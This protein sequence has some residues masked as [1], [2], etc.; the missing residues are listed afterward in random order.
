MCCMSSE[1]IGS[2]NKHREFSQDASTVSEPGSH[3]SLTDHARSATTPR[4]QGQFTT[5]QLMR[6]GDTQLSACGP[7]NRAK[8][9]HRNSCTGSVCALPRV[10][11]L[12]LMTIEEE[13]RIPRQH[14]TRTWK[15]ARR[16]RTSSSDEGMASSS[17]GA[18]KH[19][20]QFVSR[21]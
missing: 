13:P 1:S 6:I 3:Q 15:E 9:N 14:S 8:Y 2:R 10:R 18:M 7:V 4:I 5:I 16:V 19:Y 12:N 17:F 20:H 11:S 21:H